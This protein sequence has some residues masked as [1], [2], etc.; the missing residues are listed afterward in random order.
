MAY[1]DFN[2]NGNYSVYQKTTLELT[3]EYFRKKIEHYNLQDANTKRCILGNITMDT[4]IISE[5]YY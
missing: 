5:T 3:E 2:I 4:L 1:K